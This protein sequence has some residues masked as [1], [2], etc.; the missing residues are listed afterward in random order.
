M[1]KTPV[2]LFSTN[3]QVKQFTDYLKQEGKLSPQL[4]KLI[5]RSSEFKKWLKKTGAA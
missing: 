5:T 4:T 2:V 1:S 3:D